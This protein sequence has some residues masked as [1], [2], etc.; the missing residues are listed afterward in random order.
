MLH[1][2][3]HRVGGIGILETAVSGTSPCD[4]DVPKALEIIPQPVGQLHL[5]TLPQLVAY[6]HLTILPQFVAKF[7]SLENKADKTTSCNG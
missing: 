7:F 1:C 2:G 4:H 3:L 5:L 6:P